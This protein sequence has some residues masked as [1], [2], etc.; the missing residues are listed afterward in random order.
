MVQQLSQLEKGQAYVY[1][2]K[3]M[4]P[5]MVM[6]PNIRSDVGIRIKVT[7]NE[8]QQRNTFW[9]DKARLLMPYS[10]CQYCCNSGCNFKIRADAEYFCNYIWDNIQSE[11]KDEES[12]RKRIYGV[13]VLLKNRLTKY[14]PKEQR[15]LINCIRI[16]L[17]RKG[18]IEKGIILHNV[19]VKNAMLN[20]HDDEV[21]GNVF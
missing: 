10:L 4:K 9:M 15:T 7:D 5:Q 17:Q 3:L 8:I 11:V 1:Y 18:A 2:H 6:T 16:A 20:N 14:V 13:P 21:M 12:L 19:K